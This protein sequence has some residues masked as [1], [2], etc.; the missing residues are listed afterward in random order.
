M[1]TIKQFMEICDFR[2]T[3][4]NDYQWQCFGHSAYCL[5]SWNGEQD[6]HTISIVFDTRTQEVYQVMAYDYANG[7]AYRMTNPNYK[8]DFTSECKERDVTD[9]AWELDDGTP[10]KYIDL[11]VENDFISK[12]TAIVAGHD[13]DTRIQLE[14][15]M[16]DDVLFQMMKLAHD[17]DITF[18]RLVEIALQEAIDQHNMLND[19]MRAE[20]DFTNASDVHF[21]NTDNP[22]D[23][24]L[25]SQRPE[26][27][28]HPFPADN[29]TIEEAHEA[30]KKA[31]KKLKKGK[32]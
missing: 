19:D 31:K 29:F 8:D 6:G 3:E 24:P 20:Y 7:R 18:N 30:V 2:I 26:V 32:K 1:I 14:I 23:F 28:S 5:D 16:P 4:G 27:Q 10:I 11:E 22:V 15:N 17:R 12:A 25:R 21:T 9:L 13:Y